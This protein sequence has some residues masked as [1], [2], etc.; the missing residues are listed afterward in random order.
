M[1]TLNRT[2]AC[3]SRLALLGILALPFAAHASPVPVD[4]GGWL[5][6]G[7]GTWNVAS[8]RNSVTQTQNAGATVFHNNTNSQ[9]QA[10]SGTIRVN[11]TTD[12]D[13]IGFVLGYR[14]G[15]LN[16]TTNVDYLLID[17]KQSDQ[18]FRE[19]N[20]TRGL[21]IS[22]VTGNIGGGDSTNPFLDA[23]GHRGVVQE[24]ARGATLGSVGWADLTEYTFELV[25]TSVLVEVFVNG[26]REISL[27][28]AF[29]DGAFGFYN[30][31]QANVTYAGLT[32]AEAPPPP[33][34]PPPP[35]RSSR[36]RASLTVKAR[37]L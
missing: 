7:T 20:A 36:G 25:F 27:A 19:V 4:L 1:H 34:P 26:L 3:A 30:M 5:A 10:L 22:R 24:L 29:R 16:A 12:D 6:E 17:W 15:D 31:S 35:L 33:P 28:G 14:A 2:R 32:Q 13:F 37:P 11:T 21:A 18:N 8:N 23:W 9:G